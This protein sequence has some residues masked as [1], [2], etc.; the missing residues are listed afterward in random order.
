MAAEQLAEDLARYC[1]E[2]ESYL[3][4]KN[5]G[6][7][8]RIVGPAFERVCS[9]A[10]RGVP[11]KIAFRGIDRY[12][13][14]YSA[15]PGRRRPVRIEFCE[16]D[17]LDAF[18]EWRRA[19][20]VTAASGASDEPRSTPPRKPTLSSHI[21]RVIARLRTLASRGTECDPFTR[22]LDRAVQE[23]EGCSDSARS[24]RGE[25]R[26]HLVERLAALE[27]ELTI[28]AIGELATARVNELTAEAEAELAPFGS[29]LH[30]E[31]RAKALEAAYQRLVREAYGLPT[32][33][34]D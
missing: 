34:Y 6:H 33:R 1:R 19:L 31:A 29:R 10:G 24:L 17:I 30:P 4:Q 12:C 21:E 27:G 25:A 26:A 8:I 16:A 11:L 22:L 32:L 20:G 23:L 7:L 9:W 15:K 13:E 2:L 14:R 18:D 28:A 3:C 5:E